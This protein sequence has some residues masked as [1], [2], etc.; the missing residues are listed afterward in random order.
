MTAMEKIVGSERNTTVKGHQ[1]AED[2]QKKMGCVELRKIVKP[3]ISVH[4]I[5]SDWLMDCLCAAGI[6]VFRVAVSQ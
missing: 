6:Y 3:A 4:R 1:V 5:S 2:S